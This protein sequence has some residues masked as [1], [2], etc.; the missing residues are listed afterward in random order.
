LFVTLEISWNWTDVPPTDEHAATTAELELR[1]GDEVLTL[2]EDP[3]GGYHRTVTCSLY[4]LADWIARNWWS[5][6][7]DARP[8]TALPQLRKTFAPS[9][10]VTANPWRA[11]S[12][13]HAL[14][15]TTAAAA[16]YPDLL[17]V[18]EDEMTR[19]N[20]QRDAGF[21]PGASER[22]LA[23]GEALLE[24]A[25]L[26]A[27]LA[28][29]VESVIARL[30]SLG[31]PSALPRRWAA[32][33]DVDPEHAEFCRAAAWLGLDPNTCGPE[34]ADAIRSVREH[35]DKQLAVDFLNAIRPE[36]IDTGLGWV[37]QARR[38]AAEVGAV[39][40][41]E[42]ARL[43]DLRAFLAESRPLAAGPPHL[44]GWDL[45]RHIR[46][47][48]KIADTDPFDPGFLIRYRTLPMPD[49]GVV[50]FASRAGS[51]PTVIA[52]RYLPEISSRFLQARVLWHVL[53]D[54][55]DDFL[56]TAT[57]TGRQHAGRAFS[58]ELISPATG[59]VEHLGGIPNEL[60]SS[61]DLG[62]ISMHY[63]TGDIVIEHQLDIQILSEGF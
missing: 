46:R 57:H 27:T 54:D 41:S 62:T 47:W 7:A 23:S 53:T 49:P 1:L 52:A 32:I 8:G 2:V 40:G 18:T 28:S 25:T 11:R 29:V 26:M 59:I 16:H 13:R 30:S 58:V 48:A 17:I 31:L 15:T 60:L 51:A 42:S 44:R 3:D 5:L 4:P 37:E 56:I 35:L 63:V 20:W 6:V 24:S 50:G 43:A 12:P 36:L 39:P 61:E 45:A 55:N 10:G 19:L 21:P 14:R 38:M 34:V 33:R 9:I 22:Y